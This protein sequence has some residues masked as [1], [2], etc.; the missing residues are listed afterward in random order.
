MSNKNSNKKY[1]LQEDVI[2]SVL[3][4]IEENNFDNY[5]DGN[6]IKKSR[7]EIY[8]PVSLKKDLSNI[9]DTINKNFLDSNLNMTKFITALLYWI[10]M[11][12]KHGNQGNS[13]RK[14]MYYSRDIFEYIIEQKTIIDENTKMIRLNRTMENKSKKKTTKSIKR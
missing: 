4:T 14:E 8:L 1:Q 2:I 9:I 11:H 12:E 10:L 7:T 5:I 13:K 6:K 3:K